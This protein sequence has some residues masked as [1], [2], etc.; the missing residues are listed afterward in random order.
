MQSVNNFGDFVKDSLPPEAKLEPE[1]K[2]A[3]GKFAFWLPEEDGK[4][5]RVI[6]K[7]SGLVT[8]DGDAS[9]FAVRESITRAVTDTRAKFL[10]ATLWGEV[11]SAEVYT[12]EKDGRRYVQSSDSFMVVTSPMTNVMD[13]VAKRTTGAEVRRL[14]DRAALVKNALLI[15][16]QSVNLDRV[17]YEMD[18]KQLSISDTKRLYDNALQTVLEKH[19]VMDFELMT[20]EECMM[21]DELRKFLPTCLW[22]TM[23]GNGI[24]AYE[25]HSGPISGAIVLGQRTSADQYTHTTDHATNGMPLMRILNDDISYRWA[26]LTFAKQASI[27]KSYAELGGKKETHA[28]FVANERKAVQT[29]IALAN[30]LSK[31]MLKKSSSAFARNLRQKHSDA[32]EFVRAVDEM[33]RTDCDR[34]TLSLD[35]CIEPSLPKSKAELS[36]RHGFHRVAVLFSIADE[37]CGEDVR[38]GNKLK[39]QMVEIMYQR[40]G[41]EIKGAPEIPPD[42][43]SN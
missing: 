37:V 7:A 28:Q 4:R 29:E 42:A 2:M 20:D 5:V 16:L 8:E 43:A 18:H 12:P 10:G 15:R 1:E 40:M 36:L 22:A 9:W 35:E 34:V 32:G 33:F 23:Q 24:H 39:E 3:P 6:K 19:A 38:A 25:G 11:E 14:S 41:V 27:L 30:V 21:I 26:A 17:L 13:A 31:G